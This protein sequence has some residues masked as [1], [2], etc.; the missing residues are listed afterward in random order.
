MGYQVNTYQ[1]HGQHCCQSLPEVKREGLSTEGAAGCSGLTLCSQGTQFMEDAHVLTALLGCCSHTVQEVLFMRQ[2]PFQ[3]KTV[4]LKTSLLQTK[5][6]LDTVLGDSVDIRSGKVVENP[7]YFYEL[8]RHFMCFRHF[9]NKVFCT[10]GQEMSHCLY[11]LETLPVFNLFVSA[12]V[13]SCL[14]RFRELP[15]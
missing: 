7:N 15:L 11:C 6:T 14:S 9:L 3:N 2:Q 8:L 1:V 12:T 5:C 13:V 10:A 4:K